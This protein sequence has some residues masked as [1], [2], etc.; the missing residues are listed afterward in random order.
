M[1][2][3]ALNLNKN[4]W[5]TYSTI[6]MYVCDTWS[7]VLTCFR[8]K[9]PIAYTLDHHHVLF[10]NYL[11][12]RPEAGTVGL[13]ASASTRLQPVQPAI[14]QLQHSLSRRVMEHK[15][16]DIRLCRPFKNESG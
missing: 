9:A 15:T 13:G 8:S 1:S 12:E 11:I 4:S 5:Y 3:L 16:S 6:Y 14:L 2:L 7:V 10:F